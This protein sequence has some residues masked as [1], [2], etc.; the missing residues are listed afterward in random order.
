MASRKARDKFPLWLHSTG[1]WGKKIKGRY[2]YFGTDRQKALAEYVRVRE[3]LEAG[4][5][6]RPADAE[7]RAVA[8]VVNA[9]LT[10]K[11][12]R[13]DAGE[14]SARTWSDYYAACEAVV[15]GFGRTRAVSDLRPED[16]ARL[17]A[18]VAG[19]LGPVSVLNFVTRVRVLFKFASD[20]GL[21]DVPIRYGSGFDRPAKK[22]LRLERA[23][24][25]AKLIPAADLWE[26]IGAADVQLRAM[27]L[28]GLN[29]GMGA[30]DCAQ[31]PRSAL[32]LRPGWLDY[33][34]VKTGTPRRFPL[35]PETAEALAAVGD[36]RPDPKDPAD[37]RLVF[38]TR[39]G[40][41]W[42]RFHADEKGKRSVIDSAGQQFKKLG[43]KCGVKL[44]GGFYV[45]RHVHRTVSDEA[46]DRPAADLVMGHADPT[47]TADYRELVADERLLAVVNRVR[48]WLL[49][50]KPAAGGAGQCAGV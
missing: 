29:G 46:R 15:G 39:L 4:R 8:D 26:L 43:K 35:W 34:R 50:G 9:F 25:G 21:I 40:R 5:K 19:R 36:A 30:S 10:E 2:Y 28:L 38:L 3:D 17:R 12:N 33:S 32:E 20:F 42:V 49:A 7:G 41:P 23:R 31:L 18:S 45:L 27:I 1:Q 6:P 24:K 14:L 48:D 44:P 13:V 37:D 22:T 16:F 11:K 47:V